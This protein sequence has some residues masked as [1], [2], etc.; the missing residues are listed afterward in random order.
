MPATPDDVESFNAM[1]E[2][3]KAGG[4]P[5]EVGSV[6]TPCGR[7]WVGIELCHGDGSPWAGAEYVLTTPSGEVR[8]GT[9]DASGYAVEEDVGDAG[10]CKVEFPAKDAVRPL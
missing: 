9:L 1:N 10:S 3:A 2:A 4:R 8:R 5:T 6:G 7:S